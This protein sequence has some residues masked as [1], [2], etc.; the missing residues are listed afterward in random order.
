MNCWRTFSIISQQRVKKYQPIMQLIGKAWRCWY[1]LHRAWANPTWGANAGKIEFW[2]TKNSKENPKNASDMKKSTSY[3]L[4]K[5]S[6]EFES[7]KLVKQH[8]DRQCILLFYLIYVHICSFLCINLSL[9]LSIHPSVHPFIYLCICL[10]YVT[11]SLVIYLFTPHFLFLF[12][13]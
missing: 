11:I 7:T 12:I 8:C 5:I 1:S 3:D 9:L 13:L 4:M 6:R 2:T 10:R